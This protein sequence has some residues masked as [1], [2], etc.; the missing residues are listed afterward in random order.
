VRLAGLVRLSAVVLGLALLAGAIRPPRVTAQGAF[1]PEG[2]LPELAATLD[3]EGTY[4]AA[5]A[6]QQVPVAAEERLQDAITRADEQGVA[7]RIAVLDQVPQ[8]YADLGA[9]ADTLMAQMRLVDGLLI[10]ATPQ[11]LAARSDRLSPDQLAPLVA[12]GEAAV[13][14]QDLVGGIT[15]AADAAVGRLAEMVT[16]QPRPT[17]EPVT[18]AAPSRAVAPAAGRG[19]V[20]PLLTGL[21]VLLVGL[22]LYW[23]TTDRRWREV[24]A[25]LENARAAAERLASADGVPPATAETAQRR[26]AIGDRALEALRAVPWWQTWIW[27]WAPPPQ[28]ALA[29]RAYSE[30]LR[31]VGKEAADTLA[32]AVA[33][34][35]AAPPAP[36]A[37]PPEATAP[38]PI[39]PSAA[40]PPSSAPVPT[41]R[42]PAAADETLRGDE[43][44][45]PRGALLAP[46]GSA[47]PSPGALAPP[48]AAPP[49]AGGDQP[50]AAPTPPAAL[51]AAAADEAPTLTMP[52]P[53]AADQAP[54]L[55]EPPASA[56]PSPAT[57]A[58]R[59]FWLRA[60]PSADAEPAASLDPEH[61]LAG[62]T[63]QEQIACFFCGRPLRS[64][65]AEV[66]SVALAGLPLQPLV[67]H[68]HAAQ[69]AADE[70][71]GVRARLV[72]GYTLPWFQD[73][74]FQPAWDYDPR[75]DAPSVPWD[76]L[77]GPDRLFTPPSRVVVQAGDP[78]WAALQPRG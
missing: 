78:R 29:E 64:D 25:A 34:Y 58:R 63:P 59:H 52:P 31:L 51:P 41:S 50:R 53:V 54:T 8:G 4:V 66:G 14:R 42:P 27:P 48:P 19:P 68:R 9:F 37:P 10:V 38:P 71:P 3:R 24:L 55:T 62:L 32:A 67:C 28:L 65:Q 23:W 7:L 75:D 20:W 60:R 30:A 77:P 44:P 61:I 21:A 46:A 13:Q 45:L 22:G 1:P 40:A 35:S 6:R 15:A 43:P 56:A 12:D 2:Q 70:R 39:A 47:S 76:Q 74:T 5:R 26:L 73:A 18:A 49:A 69:L 16:P 33:V 57:P 72:G 36:A 17:A 11:A